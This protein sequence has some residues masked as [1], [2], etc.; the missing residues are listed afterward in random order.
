MPWLSAIPGAPLM[1][2]G[3]DENRAEHHRRKVRERC[4]SISLLTKSRTP[5]IDDVRKDTLMSGDLTWEP[6]TNTMIYATN[7]E[8]ER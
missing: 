8:S 5:V 3:E 1:E 7:K 4:S 6:Q 2:K